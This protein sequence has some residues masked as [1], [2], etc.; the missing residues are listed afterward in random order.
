M[1]STA[2]P[3]SCRCFLTASGGS[4]H[5]PSRAHSR[6]QRYSLVRHG[7]P[8]LP[9]RRTVLPNSANTAPR[10]CDAFYWRTANFSF[11]YY[12]LLSIGHGGKY[13]LKKDFRCDRSDR[14][15][16]GRR[17]RLGRK[18]G[19]LRPSPLFSQEPGSR[20]RRRPTSRSARANAPAFGGRLAP[21]GRN[22]CARHAPAMVR[23]R[24]FRQLSA[25]D[26]AAL[27][28]KPSDFHIKIRL[29][30][31]A[32]R[33]AAALSQL[34]DR[35]LEVIPPSFALEG[36]RRKSSLARRSCTNAYLARVGRSGANSL[37]AFT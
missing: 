31:N 34:A 14:N 15:A 7:I 29:R 32:Q 21:A 9:L 24:R 8:P 3:S 4:S 26:Q 30:P 25:P 22:A 20:L 2:P 1:H 17:A 37:R 16:A 10:Q 35:G 19:D 11:I 18:R 5:P 23:V 36:R 27:T 6:L 33:S 28:I 12:R 13:L